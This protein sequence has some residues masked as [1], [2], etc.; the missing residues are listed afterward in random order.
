[1]KNV[2][3]FDHEFPTNDACKAYLAKKRWPNGVTCPRCGRTEKVY[4]LK[5]RPFH[6]VCK[7]EDCGK[8]QGYR[9]SVITR[10]IFQDT[11]IPL[12]LWFKVGY[13]MLTAKKGLSSLQVRRVIFGENSGT[14]WRTCWYMCHRWRAAMQGDI[15]QLSG[16]VEVDE[17]YVGGKDKNRHKNKKSRVL[18]EAAATDPNR[19][20]YRRR[21]DAIGFN[22]VGV[23]GAIERKGNVIC[24]VIGSQDA[25]TL[26]SFVDQTVSENVELVATDENHEYKYVRQGMPHESVNHSQDEYVRGIVHTGTIDGFWSLL[27]RGIVGQYHHVSKQ[28]LPLYLN[29]FSFRYNNRKN[30]EMF[31]DLITTCA[32]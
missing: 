2:D 21:G 9:F 1:M 4:A 26:A 16:I 20:P 3:A 25:R 17:T 28:Y 11:K 32:Q 27:K 22:K 19:K 10:T 12:K 31:A 6:W 23:I 5:A 30:P 13:L 18:R 29:E 24:R 15:T 7:N 14:D 8:R